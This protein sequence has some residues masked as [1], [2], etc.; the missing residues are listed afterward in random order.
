MASFGQFTGN[1]IGEAAAFAAGL[2]IAPLLE[3]VLQELRN[4]TWAEAPTRPL[5]PGT[6][7][8]GVAERKIAAGTGRAEAAFSGISASAFDSLVAV[9]QKSP[10]IAEGIRLIRRGQLAPADF[11][12]VLQRA[13]L[14]DE[15]VTAYQAAAVNGLKPWQEPADPAVIALGIVRS[16]FKDPG[17]L[18]VTL[19]TEGSSVPPFGQVEI[20]AISEAAASGV[21]SER[22]R[23]MVGNTGRP[24]PAHEM[25]Q[26]VFRGLANRAAFNLSILEGDIRPE[27]ADVL[28][29]V[30]RQILTAH[31]YVELHLR[32]WIDQPTMYAGTAQHGMSE[33][34]TDLFFKVL[35][36]P[37]A[38]H[39]VF[40]GMRRGG[41]YDGPTTDI[42][43]AFLKS[44]Q[45]GNERPE[46][47]NIEWAMRFTYPAPFMVRQWLKDGGD[48][49]KAHDWLYWEGWQE[50]DIE[51]IIAE[52][53]P[54]SGTGGKKALTPTQ[55]KAAYHAGS[56]DR[57]AALQRL[58]ADGYS[59]IDADLLLG[60]APA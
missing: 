30:S 29:D 41:V 40:L 12:T 17:F 43:P 6:M 11:V 45:E 54:A 1:T 55:I 57:A 46:W 39:R 18:P 3:P 49:Q 7:A 34:D 38:A 22:L 19:D 51:A 2:A 31:D 25:A 47:Y 36:R 9:M 37:T 60:P 44:L 27:Y 48:T 58:E 24:G 21:D 14:E 56:I 28:F 4:T 8:G 5:D 23:A 33:A 50:A 32:G 15:F 35:G 13:G 20:D 59:A 26:A 53:A 42:D 16:I 52:Y 10:A